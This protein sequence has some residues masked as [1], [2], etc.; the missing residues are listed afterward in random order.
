MAPAPPSSVSAPPSFALQRF[1][2]VVICSTGVWVALIG[3]P[4]ILKPGHHDQSEHRALAKV[5]LEANTTF[6]GLQ[7]NL[8]KLPSLNQTSHD[9]QDLSDQDN[10]TDREQKLQQQKD[11]EQKEQEQKEQEEKDR[12]QKEQEQKEQEEKDREQK[13]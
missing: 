13:E 12:E 8:Q 3:V 1:L 5:F 4:D 10:K 6:V 9:N 7:K 11:R 2:L